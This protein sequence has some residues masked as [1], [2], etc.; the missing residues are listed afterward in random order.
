LIHG[1]IKLSTVENGYNPSKVLAFQLVFPADYSITRKTDTIE[2]VLSRLRAAPDV[3]A[4]GF[5]RA[6]I[7]IPEEIHVGTF[8]PPGRALEDMRT[9]ATRPRL[10][11]VSRGYLA[12]MGVRVLEGRELAPEDT[13][14]SPPVIVIS[15]IVAQRYFGA[16][17]PVGKFVDWY[18]GR[19][20]PRAQAAGSAAVPMQ[21][22]GVVEDIRNESPEREAFP[23][24]FVEY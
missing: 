19:D 10:R 8:V 4:A 6:G 5:T 9:E 15:R 20:G 24:I 2:A 18:V 13:A 22:V 21:V 1:F 7:L 16:E 17:S 23:D 3:E 11:P 14:T 12:A